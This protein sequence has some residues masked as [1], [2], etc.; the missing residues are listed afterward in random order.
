MLSHT[1]TTMGVNLEVNYLFLYNRLT[2]FFKVFYYNEGSPGLGNNG[3]WEF[4]SDLKASPLFNLNEYVASPDNELR[5]DKVAVANATKNSSN[6]FFS[7][8]NGFELE[9]PYTQN[10]KDVYIGFGTFNRL[11]LSHTLS[12]TTQSKIEGTIVKT[13]EKNGVFDSIASLAGFGAKKLVD[14]FV[15][16]SE[17]QDPEDDVKASFGQKVINALVKAKTGDF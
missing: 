13:V 8:W 16:K 7:G 17:G 2:G 6:G 11:Y 4:D 9:F 5:Y 10:Y 1:F 3:M 12:G 15:K 14:S